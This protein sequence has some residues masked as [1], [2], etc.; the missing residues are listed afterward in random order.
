MWDALLQLDGNVLLWIQE[1]LRNPILDVIFIFITH[2]GDHGILWIA[3]ILLM[4]IMK[5]YRSSGVASALSLAST[6]LVTNLW[7]KPMIGRIRPYEVVE[8]LTRIIEKQSERSFPSGHSANGFAVATVMLL[9]LPK[10]I[11]VPIFILQCLIAL[12][13]MYVGVHYPTDVI[14]GSMIGICMGVLYS[15]II[16]FYHKKKKQEPVT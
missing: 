13:R 7:L 6:F 4:L 15:K 11:G 16:D 1:N 2:L 9:R 3:L 12:S 8:G 10:K 5:K 14:V